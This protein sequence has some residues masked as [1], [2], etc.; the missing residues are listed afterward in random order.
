MTHWRQWERDAIAKGL[1]RRCRK[2]RTQYAILCDVCQE[3]ARVAQRARLGHQPW[4][5]GS[6]GR[7]PKG[8]RP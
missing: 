8:V 5:P 6:R 2:P 1:C 3:K 4:K 7:P